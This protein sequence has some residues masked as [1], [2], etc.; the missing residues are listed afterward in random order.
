MPRHARNQNQEKENLKEKSPKN[1]REEKNTA[2]LD[3]EAHCL[4]RL[5][6]IFFQF[7]FNYKCVPTCNM[8]HVG[9]TRVVRQETSKTSRIYHHKKVGSRLKFESAKSGFQVYFLC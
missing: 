4:E 8:Q 7:W 6:V 5:T 2:T 3:T 1:R 9:T